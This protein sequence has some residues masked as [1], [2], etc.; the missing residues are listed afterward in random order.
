MAGDILIAWCHN[1]FRVYEVSLSEFNTRLCNFKSTVRLDNESTLSV[2]SM[3][4]CSRSGV[5]FIALSSNTLTFYRKASSDRWEFH[6][7]GSIVTPTRRIQ[8]IE[9]CNWASS[10][11]FS[12]TFDVEIVIRG[13]NPDLSH[14]A[15]CFSSADGGLLTYDVLGVS[16]I[17]ANLCHRNT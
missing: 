6:L 10:S 14:L 8:S 13:K 15:I 9:V 17:S 11:L 1:S 4:F 12:A 2:T 5:L 7:A 16:F 3:N